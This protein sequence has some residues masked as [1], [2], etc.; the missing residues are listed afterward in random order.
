MAN[1]SFGVEGLAFWFLR[2]YMVAHW[3]L[4]HSW[5]PEVFCRFSGDQV[6]LGLEPGSQHAG[7]PPSPW[8]ISQD[9]D[10]SH[11][12]GTSAVPKTLQEVIPRNLMII[13]LLIA[14]W[15]SFHLPSLSLSLSRCL[16]LSLSLC[17]SLPVSPC[18]PVSLSL[19]LFPPLP[20]PPSLPSKLSLPIVYVN[21]D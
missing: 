6:V 20:L 2:P 15:H 12:H 18:L 13:D 3:Q 10:I 19:S 4:G 1:V 8:V 17:A 21:W 9:S 11:P 5:C 16:S 7:H 14:N